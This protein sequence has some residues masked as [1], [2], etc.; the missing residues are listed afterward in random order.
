MA[1]LLGV[2]VSLPWWEEDEPLNADQMVGLLGCSNLVT[3][4]LRKYEHTSN[5]ARRTVLPGVA[6]GAAPGCLP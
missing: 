6:R 2:R 5:I 3:S 4:L 1:S